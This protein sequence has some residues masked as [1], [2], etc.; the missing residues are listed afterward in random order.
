MLTL[1]ERV[2]S[3]VAG[4]DQLLGGGFLRGRTLLVTGGPGT[5]KSIL[6]W[7]FLLKGAS[8]DESGLLVSLDQTEE[9]IIADMADLGLE[10]QSAL[11]SKRLSIMAGTL[12]LSPQGGS[13]EYNVSFEGGL[14]RDKPFTVT[15]LAQLIRHRVTETGATRLVVDG[16]GPLLELAA[17]SLET[18]QAVYGFVKEISNSHITTLL[19]QELKSHPNS[20]S[21]EMP[22]F[23]ADGVIKLDMGYSAGDYVRTI[24]V[25]KMRGSTHTMRPVLFKIGNDGMVVFPESRVS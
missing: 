19:T 4:L 22:Q 18:R 11:S 13:Y 7:H 14:I 5:G 16:L 20:P 3:G 9:M 6:G 12:S 15:N 10:P 21:D 25:M 24:Q 23:L 2:S 17:G 1:K 8:S